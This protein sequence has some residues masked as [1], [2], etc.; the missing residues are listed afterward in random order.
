MRRLVVPVHLEQKS[1]AA[2]DLANA[3]V[4]RDGGEVHLVTVCNDEQRAAAEKLHEELGR[5]VP[6]KAT[7]VR[8]TDVEKEILR[9]TSKNDAD[10]IFLN[11]DDRLGERKLDMIRHASTPV[12]IVPV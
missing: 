2:L 7:V 1:R 4:K 9:Y 8:G 11:V 3:I 12:M 6:T 5:E 10:A